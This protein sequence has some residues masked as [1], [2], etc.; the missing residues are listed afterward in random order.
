MTA[1]QLV[2]RDE[3][4][5]RLDLVELLARC[6]AS[7]VRVRGNQASSGCPSREHSQTGGSP[8]VS[9]DLT[10][11]VWHC[12]GCGAGGT[13]IDVIRLSGNVDVG[14]AFRVARDLAGL[15]VERWPLPPPKPR[16]VQSQ[17]LASIVPKPLPAGPRLRSAYAAKRRWTESTLARLGVTVELVGAHARLLIPVDP[18]DREQGWQAR[19]LNESTELRWLTGKPLT[20]PFG[21]TIPRRSG[22]LVLVVEGASDWVTACVLRDVNP[23]F[24]FCVSAPGAHGWT[25]GWAA[26]FEGATVMVVGDN[27]DAGRQYEERVAADCERHNVAVCRSRLSRRGK[28]LAEIVT[29]CPTPLDHLAELLVSELAANA[30]DLR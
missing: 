10:R 19:A 29:T 27:D 8:P 1:T 3:I 24:P 25:N 20:A 14:E 6:T 23:S 13:A 16:I 28:D 11:G 15:P 7:P 5:G 4:L 30:E 22:E 12:H 26:L 2:D 18:N 21:S 9:I 17:S